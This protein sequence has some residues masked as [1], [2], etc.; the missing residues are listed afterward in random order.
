MIGGINSSLSA[1]ASSASFPSPRLWNGTLYSLPSSIQSLAEI[2]VLH[3]FWNHNLV[4]STILPHFSLNLSLSGINLRV[5]V[6][7]SLM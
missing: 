3:Q 5:I 4:L 7:Y 6:G 2:P 1:A